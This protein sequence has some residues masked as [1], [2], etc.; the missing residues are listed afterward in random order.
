MPNLPP[1]LTQQAP[2]PMQGMPQMG[3]MMQGEEQMQEGEQ[4]PVKILA[5]FAPEELKY[6]DEMQ[7]GI[8]ID[9]ETNL[10][11]Y[12]PL[13]E[14]LKDPQIRQEISSAL[15]QK[16]Q[17]FA[18]GGPVDQ[19]GR[20]NDPELEKLRLEGR[21]GDT[22]LVIITPDLLDIFSEW[23]GREPDINPTTGLPEFGFFTEILRIAAPIVGA[24]F[25]GPA[26]AFAAS[27]FAN[28]VTG[29]S[30][31]DSLKQGALSGGLAFGAGALGLGGLGGG[32]GGS[33]GLGS[34][35]GV[36]PGG[37]G[38]LF[39]GAGAG[40]G[41][42]LGGLFGG[43]AK[44]GAGA[45][46]VSPL[47]SV[48]NMIPGGAAQGAGQSGA[49]GSMLGAGQGGGGGFLGNI[50]SNPLLP[51][52]ASGL[53][54]AK[55]HQDEKKNLK[56]YERKQQEQE[57][58]QRQET[59]AM[60]ERL[61]YNAKLRP[62][63]PFEYGSAPEATAEQK[64][65]GIVP[66]FFSYSSGGAIKGMGKGQE[67]NIPKDIAENSYIIDASTVSD[68]GDGST[69]AGFKELEKYFSK[70]PSNESQPQNRNE[71]KGGVIKAMVSDGEYEISPEKV[72]AIGGGSNEKGAKILKK[73]V[74]EVRAKKRN[75]G[76]KLPPKAK[77]IGGYLSKINQSA[78]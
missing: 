44:A 30:W 35:L 53:L 78:A 56:D 72:T 3:Q 45:S 24:I 26:G 34:M 67:D 17:M 33:G 54:Y 75:S 71:A 61:G 49:L 64:A 51:L 10:R 58:K 4:E 57:Q 19:P 18:E 28:K 55:G 48:G 5:H 52:A 77:P 37:A 21:N 32:I 38:G 1:Q 66:R 65:K 6:L 29:K 25:G 13:D 47:S 14:A 70:I 42:G 22:E 59:E 43:G 73:F 39:G 16:Q 74:E 63:Q 15:S 11:E 62:E 50:L 40:A 36:A 9:P 69:D 68:I 2:S 23:S 12:T 41:G 7:G 27:T 76:E 20:P 46:G 8:L 31:G 60:R